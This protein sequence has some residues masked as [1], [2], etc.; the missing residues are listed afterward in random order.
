VL[1]P[2]SN[3]EGVVLPVLCVLLKHSRQQTGVPWLLC[4]EPSFS[5]AVYKDQ[6]GYDLY[7][8]PRGFWCCRSSGREKMG[9]RRG[10][11]T[12]P[13]LVPEVT[14]KAADMSPP[15]ITLA[16]IPSW[17]ERIMFTNLSGQPIWTA[18][19]RD[20]PYLLYWMLWLGLCVVLCTFLEVVLVK[21]LYLSFI[22]R[23]ENHT[24]TQTCVSNN[25]SLHPRDAC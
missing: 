2:Q 3:Q 19:P 14:L 12:H 24:H 21:K 8:K 1:L 7:D 13:C 15:S 22:V 5:L 11:K 23:Y 6:R 10:A 18:W 9:K 17:Q 16:S 20:L 4:G 25:N